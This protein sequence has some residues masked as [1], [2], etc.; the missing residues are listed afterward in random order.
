MTDSMN[1]YL[2]PYEDQLKKE[3][4]ELESVLNEHVCT[5][6]HTGDLSKYGERIS[7]IQDLTSDMRDIVETLK[8]LN[9][10]ERDPICKGFIPFP[11]FKPN[12]PGLYETV[13]ARVEYSFMSEWDGGKWLIPLPEEVILFNPKDRSNDQ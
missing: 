6:L 9:E 2:K 13:S 8:L 5:H 11:A 1:R 7:E 3:L 12:E 10:I 4:S